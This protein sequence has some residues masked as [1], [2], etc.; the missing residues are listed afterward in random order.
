MAYFCHLRG[1]FIGDQV[2]YSCILFNLL[3][4]A[5]MLALLYGVDMWWDIHFAYGRHICS[6]AYANNVKCRYAS[7]SG[8]IEPSLELIW[9]ICTDMVSCEYELICI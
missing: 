2:S 6:G 7:V 3:I 1:M 9:G 4:C 5:V 8:H